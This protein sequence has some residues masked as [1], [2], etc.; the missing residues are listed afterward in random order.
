MTGERNSVA[1]RHR[2]CVGVGRS[3]LTSQSVNRPMTRNLP[4]Y[5][6]IL[7]VLP[8]ATA[9]EIRRAYL[10]LAKKHHP[11]ATGDPAEQAEIKR[12]NDAFRVLSDPEARRKY[13]AARQQTP[14]RRGR[15]PPATRARPTPQPTPGRRQ[16]VD[17]PLTP[18]ESRYGATVHA[19]VGVRLPCPRCSAQ[20]AESCSRCGGSGTVLER[21]KV[22]LTIPPAC[23]TG[24]LL[25][26]PLSGPDAEHA[27]TVLLRIVVRPSW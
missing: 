19:T 21:R 11:D 22:A 26:L 2:D 20:A 8:R 9:E 12:I 25:Q 3:R 27:G 16:I 7:G 15:R 18:E 1:I 24:T 13:D 10:E 4:N 6:A 14:R 17:F 5:Y 23:R